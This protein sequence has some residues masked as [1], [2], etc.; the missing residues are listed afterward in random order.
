L[1]TALLFGSNKTF[2][3]LGFMEN[4]PCQICQQTP[5]KRDDVL[6]S[7]CAYL[8]QIVAELFERYP[9]LKKEDFD[10]MKEIYEWRTK[11]LKIM[12]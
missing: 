3:G 6:C 12:A 10:S 2:V 4:M 11:K 9:D 7:D 8:Y 1:F 5:A